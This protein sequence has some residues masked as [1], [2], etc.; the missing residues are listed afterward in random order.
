MMMLP[1]TAG[2]PPKSFNH[3]Y[4]AF[5]SLKF[6]AEPAAFLCAIVVYL[7]IN[8]RRWSNSCTM[9]VIPR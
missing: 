6:L 1:A 2:C 9:I 8:L 4:L 5:E 7:T 3:L